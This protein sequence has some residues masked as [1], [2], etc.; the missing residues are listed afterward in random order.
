MNI[1]LLFTL[2]SCLLGSCITAQQASLSGV[3]LNKYDNTPVSFANVYLENTSYGTVADE[4]GK[5]ILSN[6]KYAD[7][8]LLMSAIG[9]EDYRQTIKIFKDIQN[10]TLLSQTEEALFDQVL[11]TGNKTFQSIY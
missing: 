4:Q 10:Y 7:Y 6:I 8:E 9:Y 11:I 1:C 3:V 5:F 2:L